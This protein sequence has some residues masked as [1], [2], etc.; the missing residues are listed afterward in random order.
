MRGSRRPQVGCCY[1]LPASPGTRKQK[2]ARGC[3]A[4]SVEAQTGPWRYY[5]VSH[6]HTGTAVNIISDEK[7]PGRR[8][9]GITVNSVLNLHACED[10]VNEM[11]SCFNG[12]YQHQ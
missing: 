10:T 3:V 6:T 8:G 12:E 9:K 11:K 1:S 4:Q 7:S 2:E 5:S